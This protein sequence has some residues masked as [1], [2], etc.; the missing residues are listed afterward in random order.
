MSPVPEVN[1]T[2]YTPL[3]TSISHAFGRPSGHFLL[4]EKLRNDS[5]QFVTGFG[6][7]SGSRSPDGTGLREVQP[8][9]AVLYRSLARRVSRLFSAK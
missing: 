2:L 7:L 4:S 9:Q 3:G 6:R 1:V 5:V 8:A